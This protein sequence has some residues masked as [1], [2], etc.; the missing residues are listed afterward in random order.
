M[1]EKTECRYCTK[2]KNC[3]YQKEDRVQHC[4]FLKDN[5]NEDVD[6]FEKIEELEKRI[7]NIEEFLRCTTTFEKE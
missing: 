7:A 2:N 6:P 4:T 5:Y 1:K 3:D